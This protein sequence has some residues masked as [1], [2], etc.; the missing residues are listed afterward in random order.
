M[1]RRH[2][3]RR[4]PLRSADVPTLATFARGYLHQ[5]LALE[6]RNARGAVAAFSA[7]SP[8]DRAAL[9]ADLARTIESARGWPASR[10]RRFF[11]VELGAA[12]TP[13]SIEDLEALLASLS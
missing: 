4:V 1:T 11:S 3:P 13:D 12:W 5:D 7:D 6:T 8:A 10:L 2:G 9:A